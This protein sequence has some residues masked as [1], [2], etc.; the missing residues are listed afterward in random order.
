MLTRRI[1][2]TFVG[3]ALLGAPI[4]AVAGDRGPSTPEERKQALTYIEDYLS[5]PLSAHNTDEREWVLKWVIEVPDVHVKVC[6]I[7][8]QLP[9]GNKKHGADIFSGEVLAQTAYVLE[10]PMNTDDLNAQ[11]EAGVEGALRVYAAVVK[12]NEKDRQPFLDDLMKRRDEGTL[13]DFV[14]ERATQSCKN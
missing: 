9:K 7:L 3:C 8:D 10:H 13:N 14:K 6:M 5:D 12:A 1:A 11:L 2:A 4:A